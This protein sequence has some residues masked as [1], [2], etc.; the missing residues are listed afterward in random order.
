[1]IKFAFQVHV[2]IIILLSLIKAFILLGL[3][4]EIIKMENLEIMREVHSCSICMK[5][6]SSKQNLKQHMNIHT[7]RRPFKCTYAGCDSSYKHASQL[8]NHK[9][10]HR[11]QKLKVSYPFDDFKAFIGL[12]VRALDAESVPKVKIPEG[13]FKIENI[14]LPPILT[15]KIG[16]KLPIFDLI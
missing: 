5:M 10:L 12:V 8:S 15:P 2:I 14:F 13:P 1:L 7:G 3:I 4:T 9:I 11:P 16:I 6:L